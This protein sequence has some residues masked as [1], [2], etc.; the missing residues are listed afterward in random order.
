MFYSYKNIKI[1][2]Q[3]IGS[4]KPVVMIHGLDCDLN[5]M[6]G[7]FEPI[8]KNKNGYKRIYIDLPGMG[9][10]EASLE[11][12]S[13][14]KILD[15]LLSF[16]ENN[17]AENFLLMGE[18]YGGYLSRG[19]LS[20]LYSKIDGMVLLCPVVI[21][22]HAKRDV[23]KIAVK[24][25]DKNFMN[26]LNN[27]ERKTFGKFSVLENNRVYKR[28]KNEILS[29]IKKCDKDFI[30]LLWKNYS[31]S[32]DVDKK[33]K[34][35]KFDKPVL[36]MVGRQDICV[37][38]KDLWKLLEDYPRATFVIIDIAGHNLQIEQPEVFNS[39]VENFLKRVKNYNLYD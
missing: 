21:P 9:K 25:E 38:Y 35:I 39:L 5:L 13:S 23:P 17:I 18:S 30:E 28:Y 12:A 26:T 3:V 6:R 14:D 34:K 29:G 11:Y 36:F 32:F 20:K 15:I 10:S 37:G 19:I 33:L 8:F 27:F 7:C 4:G 16:I 1:H 31:F 24:F 2:Y 22:T